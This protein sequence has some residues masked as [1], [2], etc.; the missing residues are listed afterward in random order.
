MADDVN[1]D[2]RA[3]VTGLQDVRNLVR[4][5]T[6]LPAAG[7]GV[8]NLS[9]QFKQ[10]GADLRAVTQQAQDLGRTT[11]AA[12]VQTNTAVATVPAGI[13]A[14][15]TETKGL[16]TDFTTTSRQVTSLARGIEQALRG[17]VLGAVRSLTIAMRGI[18][19][20]GGGA[21]TKATAA[22]I[23]DIGVAAKDA[24]KFVAKFSSV[25]GSAAANATGALNGRLIT[26]FG[27]TAERALLQ[28]ELAAQ[29]LVTSLRN[30]PDAEDRAAAAASL[31][32]AS[33]AS[34][35]PTINQM[36]AA[37]EAQEK[38]IADVLLAERNLAVADADLAAAQAALATETAAATDPLTGDVIA[39]QALANAERDATLAAEAQIT[40]QAEVT[41]A[42]ERLA[43]S[44]GQVAAAAET[45]IAATSGF[46]AVLSSLAIGIGA[47]LAIAGAAV[48]IFAAFGNSTAKAGE[49]TYELAQ[50][51]GLTYTAVQTLS[52][53]AREL[54]KDVNSTVTGFD[55]YLKN[56][57]EANGGSKQLAFLMKQL[58][59]DTQK[60]A[61]DSD[62]ALQ[63]LFITIHSLPPGA[64][65]IDAA[66]KLAG[67][68]G[69]D[70]IPII[71]AAGGSFDD[72]K[73][74]AQDA[75]VI[76]SDDAVNASHAYETS[77]HELEAAFTGI[78]NT[79]GAELIPTL[80]DLI[81]ATAKFIEDNRQGFADLGSVIAAAFKIAIGIFLAF[82]GAIGFVTNL[83]YALI[84]VNMALIDALVATTE[85]AYHLGAAI[86]DFIAGNITG[87]M[88]QFSSALSSVKSG[89]NDA[90]ESIKRAGTILAQP[91]FTSLFKFAGGGSSTPNT[92]A[93]APTRSYAGGGAPKKGADKGDQLARAQEELEKAR[94]KADEDLQRDTFKREETDLKEH[95]QQNLIG[96]EQ[97]YRDL[98][99]IQLKDLAVQ[100]TYQE[101]LLAIQQRQLDATKKTPDRLKIE[102]QMIATQTKITE[103]ERQ[104]GDVSRDASFE[105]IKAAEA[106]QKELLSVQEELLKLSDRTADAAALRID[107]QYKDVLEKAQARA[108]AT[109][110]QSEVNKIN[111]LK[112]QLKLMAQFEEKSNRIKQLEE[113]RSELEARLTNEVALGAKTQEQA[114]TEL[115]NYDET[116]KT[117]VADILAGMQKV[118]DTLQNPALQIAVTKIR[119]EM[120]AWDVEHAKKSVD[121]LKHEIDLLGSARADSEKQINSSV[122]AG[123]IS[124][125]SA[126]DQRTRNNAQ[127]I[128]SVGV[129]LNRLEEIAKLTNNAD[130]SAFVQGARADLRTLKD[131]SDNLGKSL[132]DSFIGSFQTLFTDL[133][134]GTKTA[135]QAFADFGLSVLNILEQVLIKIILTKLA[136]AAF[137]GGGSGGIGGFLSGLFGGD[138]A[139]GNDAGLNLAGGG[140]VTG[141]GTATSDS[142]PIN[143]SDGEFM[144]NAMAT[145]KHYDTLMAINNDVNPRR[146]MVAGGPINA[147]AQAAIS[148]PNINVKNINVLPNDLLENYITSGDGRTALLNFMESNQSAVK[149]RLG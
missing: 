78:K 5:I 101:K 39:T 47:V 93:I 15:R 113:D 21:S 14:A 17:N 77:L 115:T 22:I 119:N 38:A 23:N 41:A 112:D 92:P 8:N 116:Q 105:A 131:D 24:E 148:A 95:F 43:A 103:L 18:G 46:T 85:T 58:G 139:V 33:T 142:I 7:A 86:F 107:Q 91:T 124:E 30:I 99:T 66:M 54:G 44:Y 19:T 149:Q 83:I 128:A 111:A 109:G 68:S 145:A 89:V 98:E 65:Q 31:F 74:K 143:G 106:Y 56:I 55:R 29:R 48:L 32:G 147:P 138:K 82:G 42:N 73:K 110:D 136:L 34:V 53:A 75:G 122:K 87:A 61:K 35:L 10:I 94:L 72:F 102:A 104:R 63:Q 121:E 114:N 25:L 20:G 117:V 127:Y 100:I 118:A 26:D 70:L 50:K 59:I 2:I 123:Q 27:I 62:N 11:Q 16:A 141:A 146:S 79:I 144:V 133:Q 67:K 129:L 51:T 125:Q 96:Y 64:Q 3:L 12:M 1:I 80:V 28:P 13:R 140:L 126:H 9:A 36:I 71:N 90:I 137:G 81:K 97:Y 45:E 4:E 52:F 120:Q 84:T 49:K 6:S 134:Q 40:A 76:L 37:Q 60:A 132:N 135:G 88:N 130:L 108:G 69:A 57:N